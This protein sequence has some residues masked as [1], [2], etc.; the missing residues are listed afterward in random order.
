MMVEA[1]RGRQDAGSSTIFD[2]MT[3]C[4]KLLSEFAP[5]L[6]YDCYLRAVELLRDK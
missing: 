2:P 6:D 5:N 4:V 1:I 3:K